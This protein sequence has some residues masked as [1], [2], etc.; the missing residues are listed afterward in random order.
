MKYH[1]FCYSLSETKLTKTGRNREREYLA[2]QNADL[3]D[4]IV[5]IKAG[6][7]DFEIKEPG[8]KEGAAE[9]FDELADLVGLHGYESLVAAV[10]A[11]LL[12][13]NDAGDAPGLALLGGNARAGL[14]A[15]DCD[16]RLRV[17][18]IG[19]GELTFQVAKLDHRLVF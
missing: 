4:D 1:R 13:K 14:G 3:L 2:G 16:D 17:L 5:G 9:V 6:G 11:V 12:L 15:R 18:R 7:P 19:L 8:E 10:L